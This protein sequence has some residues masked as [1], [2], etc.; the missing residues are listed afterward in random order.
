MHIHLH[1]STHYTHTQHMHIPE[2]YAYP[3]HTLDIHT[4]KA[5]TVSQ[6]HKGACRQ[7]STPAPAT[8]NTLQFPR[9]A[10]ALEM[11]SS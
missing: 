3:P 4:L 10:S 9:G 1:A 11:G 8:R 5:R 7:H 2:M 6:H